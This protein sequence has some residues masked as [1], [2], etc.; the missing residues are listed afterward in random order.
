MLS[1]SRLVTPRQSAKPCRFRKPE[2]VAGSIARL[3]SRWRR[4]WRLSEAAALVPCR[5][6]WGMDSPPSATLP[7]RRI[8]LVVA[9]PS[10]HGSFVRPGLAAAIPHCHMHRTTSSHIIS[11]FSHGTPCQRPG[12]CATRIG[13]KS[14]PSS[15]LCRAACLTLRRDRRHAER[16]HRRKQ[17]HQSTALRREPGRRPGSAA[18]TPRP[19]SAQG[20]ISV[21]DAPPP[22][23]APPHR[24]GPS[25]SGALRSVP[26]AGA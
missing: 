26:R 4:A 25:G 22:S 8:A 15:Q 16:G 21:A 19:A 12:C 9:M 10:T 13:Q 14:R 1:L 17:S 11:G 7:E 5:D 20:G 2:G 6:P 23:A 24:R 3:E 18:R